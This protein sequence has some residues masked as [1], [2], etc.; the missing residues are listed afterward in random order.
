LVVVTAGMLAL[1]PGCTVPA[2]PSPLPSAGAGGLAAAGQGGGAGVGGTAGGGGVSG[3]GV[4]GTAGTGAT[5]GGGFSG[6]GAGGVGGAGAGGAGAGGVAAG[7]GGAGGTSGSGPAPTFATFKF[8][9]M[10]T[11]PPC[12]ASD[13]H[14]FGTMNPLTLA[15]DDGMLRTRLTTTIN[16]QCGNI[17]VVTPGDPTRSALIMLLKGPCG[18]LLRMPEGCDP[19]FGQCVPDEYIAAIEE[20]VRLGAPP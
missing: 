1:L 17:P 3:V 9:T 2:E 11:Q 15:D 12:V 20:W 5:A 18:E 7:G 19:A 13:C 16:E 4:G 8:V 10:N 6:F 14:G